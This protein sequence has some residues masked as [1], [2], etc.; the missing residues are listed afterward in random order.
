MRRKKN[1]ALAYLMA[2]Y[3]EKL[4]R[5]GA[6]IPIILTIYPLPPLLTLILIII[7]VAVIG[8]PDDKILTALKR[9]N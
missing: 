9:G 8:I 6:V 3:K 2:R 1:P 7:A 4:S 5:I